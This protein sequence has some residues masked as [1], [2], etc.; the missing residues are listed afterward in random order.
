MEKHDIMHKHDIKRNIR[1]DMNIKI[2]IFTYQNNIIQINI[3]QGITH[4]FFQ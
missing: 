1:Y 3:Y 2:K 4:T